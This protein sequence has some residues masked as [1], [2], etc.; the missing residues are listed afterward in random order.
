M[1]RNN[2]RR[3]YTLFYSRP[4]QLLPV[5]L[6][7][8]ALHKNQNMLKLKRYPDVVSVGFRPYVRIVRDLKNNPIN[9]NCGE[10][11][12]IIASPSNKSIDKYL[13]IKGYWPSK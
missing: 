7:R 8:F 4:V 6:K 1:L 3:Y 2:R 13:P 5:E 10:G 9:L 11:F 12:E